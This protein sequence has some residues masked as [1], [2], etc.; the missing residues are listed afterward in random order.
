M[1]HRLLYPMLLLATACATEKYY[2]G[3]TYPATTNPEVFV[4]WNDLS[5]PYETMG[6]ITVGGIGALFSGTG[7]PTE[8]QKQIEEIAREKGAD[9]IV[10]GPA[11]AMKLRQ[12]AVQPQ[13][14][15]AT[16]G[17]TNAPIVADD[18]RLL[19]AAFIKYKDR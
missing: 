14:S 10:I 15:V 9:A 13:P 8:A 18:N 7:T 3:K 17:T 12:T 1:P 19:T 4:E 16:D 6:Y 2:V 11:A 5:R